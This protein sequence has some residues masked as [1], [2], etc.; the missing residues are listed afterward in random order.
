MGCNAALLFWVTSKSRR[1]GPQEAGSDPGRD[2]VRRRLGP[3][4]GC[5]GPPVDWQGY[6]AVQMSLGL[7]VALKWLLNRDKPQ[8]STCYVL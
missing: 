7:V 1:Y 8:G 6:L 2:W 4:G 5:R 3:R